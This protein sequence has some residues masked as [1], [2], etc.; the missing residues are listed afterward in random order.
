MQAVPGQFPPKSAAEIA[1]EIADLD[2][3]I[4]KQRNGRERGD[5]ST[6]YHDDEKLLRDRSEKLPKYL[7]AKKRE[8]K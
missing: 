1:V 4:A 5:R 6:T 8:G 7:E 2:V 3:Q